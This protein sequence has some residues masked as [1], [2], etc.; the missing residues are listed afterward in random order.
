MWTEPK[1]NFQ[2]I[3][4]ASDSVARACSAG[5]S[6]ADCGRDPALILI[7]IFNNSLKIKKGEIKKRNGK[8]AICD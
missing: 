7:F 3:R 1:I 8:D 4:G 5:V 6:F 2:K